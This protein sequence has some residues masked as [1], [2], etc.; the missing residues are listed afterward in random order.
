[1]RKTLKIHYIFSVFSKSPYSF[2]WCLLWFILWCEL[3]SYVWPFQF[4]YSVI[5][6]PL[7]CG[8]WTFL[9]CRWHF[10]WTK[11]VSPSIYYFWD[12]TSQVWAK[13]LWRKSRKKKR[14]LAREN[15]RLKCCW[16]STQFNGVGFLNWKM[17]VIWCNQT[18][19]AEQ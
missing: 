18:Q 12:E 8:L 2:W 6:Q 1:M 13:N 4:Q 19:R 9:K 10:K 11:K 16:S 14:S 3:M 5:S 17:S 15:I 7:S